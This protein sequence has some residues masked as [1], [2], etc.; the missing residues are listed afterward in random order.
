MDKLLREDPLAP[1]VVTWLE[2]RHRVADMGRRCASS[3]SPC[4]S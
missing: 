3:P 1:E 4:Q 2:I